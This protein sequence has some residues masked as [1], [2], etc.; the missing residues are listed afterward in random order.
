MP[1]AKATGKTRATAAGK[2][3]AKGIAP[4]PILVIGAPRSGT[5]YL[6]AVLSQHPDI[7]ISRETRIFFWAFQMAVKIPDD[8]RQRYIHTH[9]E[10]FDAAILPWTR[11]F[12]SDFYTEIGRG[13]Y[14]WGDKYP[15]YAANPNVLRFIHHLYEGAKFIHLVRDGRDVAA[16][17]LQMDWA[18]EHG[19]EGAHQNWVRSVEHASEFGRA[20][21]P[22]QYV[23]VRYEELVSD[24]HKV[25]GELLDFIGAPAH[26]AV[27][28]YL[29]K[30]AGKRARHSNPTRTQ[31][32]LDAGVSQWETLL[33]AAEQRRSLALLEPTLSAWGYGPNADGASR[34][35]KR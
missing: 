15:N 20:L 33:S 26:K 7:F 28:G 23:E 29:D 22:S 32:Q 6:Q 4:D 30:Q 10:E 19:F 12:I 3:R 2:A 25:L 14:F 9:R 13:T 35:G 34:S 8:P 27:T 24:G 21:P 18:K 31:E 17:L 1:R 11:R 16:S 5:T